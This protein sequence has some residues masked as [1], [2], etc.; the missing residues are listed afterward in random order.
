[1]LPLEFLLNKV[2]PDISCL[3]ENYLDVRSI[4]K[5]LNEIQNRIT[6][7]LLYQSKSRRHK[8]IFIVTYME[9]AFSM[10]RMHMNGNQAKR[11]MISKTQT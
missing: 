9:Y 8:T 4:N 2:C 3:P 5:I 11:W 7:A 1:M 10:Q 6:K